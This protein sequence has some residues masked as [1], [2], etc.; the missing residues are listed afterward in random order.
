M[1]FPSFP[2]RKIILSA[3]ALLAALALRDAGFW[4]LSAAQYRRTVDRWI[5][6]GRAQGYQIAFDDRQ[7]FGFPRHVTMRLVNLHVQSPD[8]IAFRTDSM[9]ITAAA[10][11]W[12]DF[13]VK[14]KN[15]VQLAAPLDDEGDA[16]T[17]A[18]EN[19]EAHLKLDAKGF[20]RQ[21]AMSLSNSSIGLAP[22]YLFQ[23]ERL[24]ASVA[25]PEIE[26]R[27][28][29][30]TGLTIVGE[31][32]HIIIPEAMPSPF[33]TKADKLSMRMRVMGKVPDVRRRDSGDAWNKDSG[34]VEFDDFSAQWGVLNLTSKGTLGFDDDLQPEGAF[35]GTI[36]N[37]E[38]TVHALI[39]QHFIAMHDQGMLAS[40]MGLFAKTPGRGEQGME[41]PI[42]IQLG[43]LFLGP[44][45]IFA[46]P[47]IEWPK[48]PPVVR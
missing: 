9:D 7:I 33:G 39:D 48:E 19:G 8:A 15:H 42:T 11:S 35:A 22:N 40:V 17:L 14:F 41:L 44:V 18:S 2:H 10:W 5:E 28:H 26:P 43:G 27:N 24:S 23:A 47:A 38:K 31:A 36:G 4:Y 32:D 13:D 45:K 1:K 46:F 34:I 3:A 6:A 30:E 25:R 20:W 16:L 37:P 12:T 29:T 21:V